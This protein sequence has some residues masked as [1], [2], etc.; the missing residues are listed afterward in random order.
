MKCGGKITVETLEFPLTPA[1]SPSRNDAVGK[2]LAL[3]PALSPGER[4]NFSQSFSEIV[5]WHF[6]A[7]DADKRLKQR[8]S[9]LTSSPTI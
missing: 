8:M 7:H 9:L 1:L 2:E 4:E 5:V 6:Q 3:T